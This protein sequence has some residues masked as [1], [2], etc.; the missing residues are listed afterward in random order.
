VGLQILSRSCT[1]TEETAT[2]KAQSGVIL[3][4]KKGESTTIL[5]NLG[6]AKGYGLWAKKA[7]RYKLQVAGN[8]TMMNMHFKRLLVWQK[9]MRLA[10]EIYKMTVVLP[11]NEQYGLSSQVKRAAISVLSNI[12]EGSQR[13]TEKEFAYFLLIAK[14]S[15]AE[16]ETQVL[17]AEDLGFWQHKDLIL[18]HSLIVEVDRMLHA[19][20][21]KLLS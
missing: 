13:T 18:I 15:L 6:K 21:N 20:R 14:G 2:D 19:F 7:S 9:S 12:A 5:V 16:L 4:G 3:L 11:N 17:L 1:G 8:P 10:K